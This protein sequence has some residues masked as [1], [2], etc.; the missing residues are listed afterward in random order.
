MFSLARTLF[1]VDYSEH[2]LGMTRYAIPC[3]INAPSADSVSFRRV[4]C[5]INISSLPFPN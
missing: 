4:L 5:P 1:P 3:Q 2:S